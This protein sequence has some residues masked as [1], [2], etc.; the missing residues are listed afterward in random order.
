LLL[1]EGTCRFGY[2]VHAFFLMTNHLPLAL[3]A[4]NIPLSR[5]FQDLSFR[6][7][8]WVN[9]REKRTGHLFQRRNNA[10]LVDSDT[11]WLNSPAP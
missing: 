5:G 9:G 1:Q 4:R 11:I 10:V 8:R 7:T 3:Q 6:Y 2:Q